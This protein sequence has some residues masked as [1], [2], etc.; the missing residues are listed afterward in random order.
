MKKLLLVLALGLMLQGCFL[1]SLCGTDGD[2]DTDPKVEHRA[3]EPNPPVI[4]K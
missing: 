4:V 1:D 3:P 2:D